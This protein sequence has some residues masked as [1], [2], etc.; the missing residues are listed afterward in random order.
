MR[1]SAFLI[2]LI[3]IIIGGV[4]MAHAETTETT[5]S[6]GTALY[7][8][9]LLLIAGTVISIFGALTNVPEKG[10]NLTKS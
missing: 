8:G 4:F 10:S 7:L 9:L 5:F 1:K 2:G 6:Y 3:L